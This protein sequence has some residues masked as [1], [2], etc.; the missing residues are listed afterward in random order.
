MADKVNEKDEGKKSRLDKVHGGEVV[1]SIAPEDLV[2][3]N[4]ADCKHKNLIREDSDGGFDE[5]MNT[6]IC[7]NPNCN[8]VFVLPKQ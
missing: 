8:E 2:S 4:D 6:F 1:E 3:F 7:S 5:S